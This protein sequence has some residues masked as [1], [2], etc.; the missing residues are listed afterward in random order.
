ML[1]LGMRQGAETAALGFAIGL[2]P[3]GLAAARFLMAL[4]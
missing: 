2:A 4:R 1:W 3:P